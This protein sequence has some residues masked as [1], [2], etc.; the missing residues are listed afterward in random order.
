MTFNDQLKIQMLFY[1]PYYYVIGEKVF[2]V[3]EDLQPIEINEDKTIEF[4]ADG[5]FNEDGSTKKP[6]QMWTS[7]GKTKNCVIFPNSKSSSIVL[8]DG[9]QY[10]YSYEVIVKLK[11]SLY[12]LLP[13]EGDLIWV[14]KSDKTINKEME[15]KGFVTYKQKYLKLWL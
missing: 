10:A 11:K 15:V 4:F 9:K 14:T 2:D 6:T 5:K 3:D 13:K 1:E 8:N 7:F 12:S